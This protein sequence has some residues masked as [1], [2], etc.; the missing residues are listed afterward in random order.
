MIFLN[1][2]GFC[3]NPNYQ[4]RD[5]IVMSTE[6]IVTFHERLNSLEMIDMYVGT[7]FILVGDSLAKNLLLS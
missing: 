3:T 6:I 7:T 1:D 4:I 2:R 5:L